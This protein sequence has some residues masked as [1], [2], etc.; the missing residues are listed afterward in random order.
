MSDLALY[1]AICSR[2]DKLEENLETQIMTAKEDVAAVVA[3]LNKALTELT[4]R[5]NSGTVTAEDL[6][7][8]RDAAQAL[9]DINPD[10][11]E[12]PTDE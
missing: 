12:P 9:D 1:W 6:Q 7:P 10:A 11:P 3:Q 2:L 8:L 4:D 5:I